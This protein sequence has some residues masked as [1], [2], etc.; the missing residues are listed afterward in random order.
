MSVA[1]SESSRTGAPP[2]GRYPG[3]ARYAWV[4]FGYILL[5][6]V[7]GAWVRITGS[8]AGCGEHWPTCHGQLVPRSP[9][10]KT[11]VEFTHRVTS[12]LLGPMVLGL[13]LWT[14]LGAG[15]RSVLR[16][17]AGIT[18]LFVVFE[19]LIG[20]GLVLGALV[21][22][23]DSW[24][25]AVVVAL[26]LGNTLILTASA[27]FTAWFGGGRPWPSFSRR[28]AGRTALLL[29]LLGLVVVSMTGAITALGDTL[30]PFHTADDGNLLTHLQQGFASDAHFLVRLR[31]LHPVLALGVGFAALAAVQRWTEGASGLARVARLGA[32]LLWAQMTIGL[33]N[34]AM[35]AP[36]WMQLLHLLMAELLWASLV[37]L[38]ATAHAEAA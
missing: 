18:V 6:I 14:W 4:V 15:K 12:G 13:W 23:D 22:N 37:V 24:A 3:F 1:S 7:Y 28:F 11:I 27:A 9:S 31:V 32:A 19:A 16:W 2:A 36:G 30:F 29:A 35:A 34:I 21:A 25:R 5:V 38:F 8:G 33:V 17:L 20:A 10:E 26:H